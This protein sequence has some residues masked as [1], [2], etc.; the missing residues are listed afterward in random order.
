MGIVSDIY[1]AKIAVLKLDAKIK[2]DLQKL[3]FDEV[4]RS[5]KE[6]DRIKKTIL[7][8]YKIIL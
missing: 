8:E 2:R 4:S 6:I 5:N 1:R 7:K 3:N